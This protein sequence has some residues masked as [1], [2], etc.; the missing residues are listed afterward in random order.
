MIQ[1]QP[2]ILLD[3]TLSQSKFQMDSF[4]QI[5]CVLL[6]SFLFTALGHWVGRG[7]LLPTCPTKAARGWG[8]WLPRSPCRAGGTGVEWVFMLRKSRALTLT[9]LF[10]YVNDSYYFLGTKLCPFSFLFSKHLSPFCLFQFML[11]SLIETF[12]RLPSFRVESL[13]Y[14]LVC[15]L[16]MLM[17]FVLYTFV[18][19]INPIINC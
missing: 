15:L 3:V 16:L 4:Q 5:S 2:V 6:C 19:K 13:M 8:R 14:P 12:N 9:D 7:R 1:A 17:W 18:S 10:H 11:F